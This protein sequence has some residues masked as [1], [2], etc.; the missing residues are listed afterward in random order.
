MGRHPK[1]FTRPVAGFC[2]LCSPRGHC[3]RSRLLP[4][5]H[6]TSTFLPTFPRRGFAIRAFRGSSS[7]RY[8]AGSD[9]CRASPARQASPVQ[10]LAFRA[11]N[12]QPRCAP[13]CHVP[14]HLR[15]FGQFLSVPGFATHPGSSPLHPAESG[16]FSYGPQVRLRLLPTPPHGDAVTFGYG[17]VAHPGADS[18]RTDTRP[19]W[20]HSSPRRRGPHF[21][22]QMGP[23][24]SRG[25]RAQTFL[26]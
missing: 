18:H 19:S 11:S 9:S 14:Y 8:Y 7:L 20:A 21:L 25:R 24:P 5:G 17:A 12:P 13:E 10:P 26:N 23:P 16:S 15:A 2:A 6:S 4:A 22:F 3:R 1:P